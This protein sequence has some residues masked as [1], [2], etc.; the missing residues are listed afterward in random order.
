VV[1][2]EATVASPPSKP[3]KEGLKTISWSGEIPPQK[4]MNFYMKIISKVVKSENLK[5][6]VSIEVSDPK[7]MSEQKIEEIKLA[8]KELGFEDRIESI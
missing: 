7:G 1:S 6:R 8:L 3:G 5:L 4:W 2:D